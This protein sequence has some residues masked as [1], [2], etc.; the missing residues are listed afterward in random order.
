MTEVT[1]HVAV[2]L[3]CTSSP[4]ALVYGENSGSREAAPGKT[5]KGIVWLLDC[6]HLSV[7]GDS[8]CF[9]IPDWSDVPQDA[10]R[11]RMFST[12]ISMTYS[13]DGLFV[14]SPAEGRVAMTELAR[15]E[16]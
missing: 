5:T 2:V 4:I 6:V 14:E 11:P 9:Y 3:N 8:R 7:G 13:E 1:A 16:F 15:C 10:F 12:H